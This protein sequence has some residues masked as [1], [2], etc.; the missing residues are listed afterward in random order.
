MNP[1]RLVP[2]A[3]APAAQVTSELGVYCGFPSGV[4]LPDGSGYLV[5]YEVGDSHPDA[6]TT[7]RLRRSA[8]GLVWSDSWSF[9][10]GADL[11]L[12]GMAAETTAQGGRIYLAAV[13]VG[14]TSQTVTSV[15]PFVRWSDDSGRTWSEPLALSGAGV[16]SPATA[17]QTWTFYPGSVAVMADGTLLIA[18]YGAANGHVYV[19]RSTDRGQTWTQDADLAGPAGRSL[20]EPQMC[21][22]ADG[23]VAMPMRADAGG[24]QWFYMSTRETT[25]QWSTPGVISYNASGMPTCREIAPGFIAYVYRGWIDRAD[26]TIRPMRLGVMS[27]GP[28]WGR[29]N[30]DVTPGET[31]RFLY[32]VLLKRGDGWLIVH[33]VEGPNGSASPSAALWALPVE[34]RPVP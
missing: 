10:T 5:G 8:D 23:R 26:D 20:T 17:P 3:S 33:S 27:V 32:G 9:A 11:G 12:A 13:R 4:E 25:G 7:H 28:G 21:V 14:F 2:V 22:L 30:I 34:F 31:G 24:A 16:R 18:G 29:G 6:T 19:R 1:T 15:A